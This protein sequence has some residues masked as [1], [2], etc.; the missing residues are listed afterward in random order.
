MKLTLSVR[1]Y[2]GG[3]KQDGGM[4]VFDGMCFD[5]TFSQGPS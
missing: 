4:L 5:A 3:G 2:H 1:S